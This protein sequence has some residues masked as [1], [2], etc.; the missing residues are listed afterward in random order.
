VVKIKA[1]EFATEKWLW[2]KFT[3]KHYLFVEGLEKNA[4]VAHRSS[5]N[6]RLECLLC[7]D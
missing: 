7:S 2:E 5:I 1:D 3:S 6:S 4:A